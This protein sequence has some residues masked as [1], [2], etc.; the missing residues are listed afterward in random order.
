MKPALLTVVVISLICRKVSCVSPGAESQT[1]SV[2]KS[3]ISDQ[4]QLDLFIRNTS[5]YDNSTK[6]IQLSLNGSSFNVDLLQLMRL[7]LGTNGSLEITGSITG[8]S[9]NINC[10][11]NITDHVELK[12]MLQPIISRALLVLLDG[13]VFTKCPV[14]ILI[15]EV[16]TVI[17]RN[18]VFLWVSCTDYTSIIQ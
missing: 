13:L 4:T 6:C 9:V 7:N 18:C 1:C 10:S 14:P 16:S 8:D 12:D 17:V 15:E 2:R 5:L 3:V 11:I